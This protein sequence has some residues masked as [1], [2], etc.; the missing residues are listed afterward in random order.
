[1]IDWKQIETVFLD[2]DGT[3]LDLHYDNYFWLHYLPR[4]YSELKELSE[5]ETQ[6]ILTPMFEEHAGSLNWYCLD[7]W[8]D[9][10]D[11]DIVALK[12]E[13]ADR[14]A[15][16]PNAETFLKYVHDQGLDVALV[17]NAH[18][19]SIELK[20]EH[21]VLG[22]LIDE[23]ITSH[24]FSFAKEEQGFW[25]ALQKARHYNP[26]KTAFFDDNEAVLRSARDS[27]IRFLY[28]IAQPD[29]QRP[30]RSQGEFP[31]LDDFAQVLPPR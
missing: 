6:S 15:F 21:T 29:S 30:P 3:L 11:L 1:M 2:M 26:E 20:L 23:I 4:R 27:G 22:S 5:A 31:M 7:F 19:H 9:S 12:R 13:V 14:I 25:E 18:R 24:D 17:T 28:S 8:A 10:L 16:R